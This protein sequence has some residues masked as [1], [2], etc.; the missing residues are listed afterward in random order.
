V[1]TIRVALA[2]PRDA[3]YDILIGRGLL[4]DL[5]ALVT[6]A[7]PASRYA[8]IT[9]SH[10]AKLYGE[11]VVAQFHDATLRAQLFEFPAGE[12][13][14]TRDSWAALS[15]GMLAAQFGR[16]SAVIAL[17]GGVVGD[18]AGF[19]AATYLRG[20]P[21]IQVPTTLL[22]MI[23]S[24]IGGKTG[25]DVP[26]GKNLLGAFHQPRLVVADLDVLGSL[27]P[28]QLAAGMAEAVKHGVIADRQYFETLEREHGAVTARDAGALERV[29]RRSVE[30]KAEVVAADERE[31]G[32]RAIL[33][34]GH[35]VGHAIEATAKFATLH[36]EAVAIGM[37][38]EARLAEALGIAEPGTAGRVRRLLE[39][40]RLP[41]DLPQSATVDALVA[42]MQL[43][44]KAREGTVRF[45]L[46]R[47]IGHMHRDGKSWTVAAPEGAVRQV[48]GERPG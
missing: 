44:K 41:L 32:R 24:S 13:N 36:G 25:V 23:D 10:V 14:K 3:S 18:L 11:R 47:A 33:N 35:T 34:F 37:A 45:A 38:Y 28:P 12:W 46:P 5:P 48:L 27:A 6:A 43:D 20:V 9:D 40:Y 31:G 19:V 21:C 22:A 4:A 39:R 30:I 29:V 1:V 8:V 17:G 2:E 16:D 15:D 7:C 42:A 26:A